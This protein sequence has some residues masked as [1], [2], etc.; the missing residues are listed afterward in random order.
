VDPSVLPAWGPLLGLVA[1]A[2]IAWRY[3]STWGRA[4]LA[5]E[6]YFV[7][8]LLPVLG[9][10]NM[11]FHDRFSLVSDHLQYSAM[12][13]PIALLVGTAAVWL[14]RWR[15]PFRV[16]GPAAVVVLIV[17]SALT[18]QRA[19]V[20]GSHQRLW[21]DTLRKNPAAWMAHYNLAIVLSQQGETEEALR[22]L[23][24]ALEIKPAFVDARCALGDL[25][26]AQGNVSDAVGEYRQALSINPECVAAH[27]NLGI[28]LASRGSLN[29][30]IGHY[31]EALDA[32]PANALV[33]YNLGN[34]L[35]SQGQ[36]EEA[37]HH[38]R[39][40]LAERPSLVEAH[41]ELADLLSMRRQ[42]DEAIHHY[43][44][45]LR[46]RPDYAE[47]YEG[48]TRARAQTRKP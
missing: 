31:R 13:G 2:G 33:H 6:A 40:A 43:S 28:V 27:C 1:V 20:Y 47:A 38:Y 10:F 8:M 41:Y 46:F 32:A 19:G 45:A 48:L 14:R 5:A 16:G 21:R 11:A 29:E 25:L 15:V 26:V 42:W 4:V 3:R 35:A 22:H 23:R 18:W 12:I 36:V 9:F 37:I 24:L 17:L 30:A 7:C 34:A 39:Q 44:E